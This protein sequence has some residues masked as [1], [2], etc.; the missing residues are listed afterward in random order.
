MNTISILLLALIPAAF[1]CER[2]PARMGQAKENLSVSINDLRKAP[3]E[4]VL[5]GR[6]LSLS[7][8]LWRDFMPGIAPMIDGKP[9]IAVLKVATS[10]KKSFPSGVRIDRAWVLFGEQMWETSEFREQSED[11]TN[12][13]DSNES[14]VNCPD[15]PVCEAVARGGPKWGPGIF[16]DVVVQ[17]TDREGRHYLLQARKQ[18]VNRTD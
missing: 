16:V 5:E 10:D 6:S 4:V 18:Y 12:N 15:S 9:M 11:P 3:T 2:F 17:L 14:W 8:Y 13:K 1:P 7:T